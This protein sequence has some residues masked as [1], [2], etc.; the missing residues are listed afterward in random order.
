MKESNISPVGWYIGSYLIRFIK[1]D[2]PNLN[3]E[4]KRFLSWENT[5]IVKAKSMEEAYINSVQ[6]IDNPKICS[7]LLMERRDARL[8]KDAKEE[9]RRQAIKLPNQA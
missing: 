7:N 2:D 3:D 1:M 5:V 8:S 6:N 9:I 4:S